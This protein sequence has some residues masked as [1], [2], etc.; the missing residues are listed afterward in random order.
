MMFPCCNQLKDG[1]QKI[2]SMM[3]LGK[4][5][6]ILGIKIYRDR[7]KRLLALSQNAYIDKV[8]KRFSMEDSKRGN[9]PMSHGMYLSKTISEDIR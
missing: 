9:L 8:L 1:F 6:Y 5:A 3:D 7:S 2:F 4:V